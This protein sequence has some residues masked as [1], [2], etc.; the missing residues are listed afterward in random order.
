[1]SGVTA[2]GISKRSPNRLFA[3][4]CLLLTVP[5]LWYQISEYGPKLGLALWDY[6]EPGIPMTCALLG[7]VCVLWLL[8]ARTWYSLT[9][10]TAS[11][12]STAMQ[13]KNRALIQSVTRALNDAIVARG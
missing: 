7:C 8:V 1:M 4:F 2:V 10:M 6:P 9:L 11:G 3:V 12:E 13:S 5:T